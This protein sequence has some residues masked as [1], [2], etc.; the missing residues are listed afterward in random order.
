MDAIKYLTHVIWRIGF[1]PFAALGFLIVA[2]PKGFAAM[3]G[4]GLLLFALRS[5]R[6]P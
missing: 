4:L 1:F 6:L 3:V 2:G 5:V